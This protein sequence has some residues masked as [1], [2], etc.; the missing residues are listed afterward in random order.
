MATASLLSHV[1]DP[2]EDP[3]ADERCQLTYLHDL[4]EVTDRYTTVTR[5]LH[6]RYVRYTAVA[7]IHVA[8]V[9]LCFYV[10]PAFLPLLPG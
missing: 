3:T 10:L 6:D 7:A 5:P 4:P 2:P 8:N 1:S 9:I